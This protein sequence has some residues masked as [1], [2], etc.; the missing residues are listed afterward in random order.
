MAT[1][2]RTQTQSAFSEAEDRRLSAEAWSEIQAKSSL[3]FS[4][5]GEFLAANAERFFE[6]GFLFG[7]DEFDPTASRPLDRELRSI[8]AHRW[9]AIRA[10]YDLN[11]DGF[12]PMVEEISEASF[13]RG[14]AAAQEHMGLQSAI[15]RLFG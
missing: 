13:T 15:S 8:A 2:S 12:D 11:F 4:A 10:N 6:T 5:M 3:D 7:L 9:N 14:Y 1:N